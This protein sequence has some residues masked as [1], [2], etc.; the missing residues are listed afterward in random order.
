MPTRKRKTDWPLPRSGNNF[1]GKEGIT[2]C[3]RKLTENIKDYKHPVDKGER[4]K[5]KGERMV[6]EII[7]ISD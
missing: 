6:D 4:K 5:T 7:R 3:F 1:F 2:K